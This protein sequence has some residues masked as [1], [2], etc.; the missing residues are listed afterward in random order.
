MV[1]SAQSAVRQGLLWLHLSTTVGGDVDELAWLRD[2][3]RRLKSENCI[4]TARDADA[5][6]RKR[7]SPMQRLQMSSHRKDLTPVGWVEAME[8]N[9]VQHGAPR[10]LISD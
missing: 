1:S 10:H 3:N 5:P 4:L 8:E 2:E 6:C 7:Y 9:L